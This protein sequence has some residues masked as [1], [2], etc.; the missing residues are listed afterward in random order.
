MSN[1]THFVVAMSRATD[2]DYF[3]A[4][5]MTNLVTTDELLMLLTAHTADLLEEEKV[6]ESFDKFDLDNFNNVQCRSLFRF[7][8]DD[9]VELTEF[10]ALPH[11]Y[12]AQNG[13]VWSPIE[14]TCMLLCR[15]CY[16]GRLLDLAP[17]FGRSVPECSLIVNNMLADVHHRFS[18]LMS[19]VSQPWMD[20][21][22]YCAAVV[23]K[24]A[25]VNNIFSFV[26]GTL[27]HICRPGQNQREMFSGHKRRHGLKFQ[28]VMLPNGI[29][30]HSFGP[31]PGSR[32][33]ASMY[34]VSQLDTQLAQVKGSDGQQLAIYG[35]AA[36]PLQPWLFAPFPEHNAHFTQEKQTFNSAMSPIRSAVEW[37]F[38]KVTSYF[39]FINFYVN[40]KLHLQPLGHY[41]QTATL[42]ANCHTCCYGSEVA[43]YFGV[44][45]PLDMCPKRCSVSILLQSRTSCPFACVPAAQGTS[46]LPFEHKS[47]KK[48]L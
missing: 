22:K 24:G 38:A 27:R 44:A 41:F 26:D 25:P 34:G 8:K 10:L 18:Y 13:M 45:P 14:G 2:Y 20:H 42:L 43:T 5:A 40:L 29:V 33:D 15:L 7:D 1:C 21:E 31:F 6:H 32:H 16:P 30:C 48:L 19:S 28:H 35:D 39:A 11:Q 36:Y 9:L 37:G 3:V 47:V 23:Q 17:Y 46:S 4:L 12:V